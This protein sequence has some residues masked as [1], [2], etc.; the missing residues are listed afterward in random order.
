MF[1]MIDIAESGVA[2]DR[3][4][5]VVQALSVLEDHWQVRDIF[6]HNSIQ[7]PKAVVNFVLSL[8]SAVFSSS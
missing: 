7:H 2:L 5:G 8:S 1:A 3:C 6:A 4:A